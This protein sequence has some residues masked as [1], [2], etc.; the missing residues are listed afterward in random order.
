LIVDVWAEL[1]AL[2]SPM[3]ENLYPGIQ[4]QGV[5]RD[6]QQ[7]ILQFV[8]SELR[9]A[10]P[11]LDDMET[12]EPLYPQTVPDM[13]DSLLSDKVDGMVWVETRME[14]FP[15]P[16]IGFFAPSGKSLSVHYISGMW[17]PVALIGFMELLRWINDLG[18]HIQIEMEQ[19]TAPESWCK[20]FNRTWQAYLSDKG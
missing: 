20:Q 6:T 16:Q 1:Q 19:G 5:D 12:G 3:I 11:V 7:Y 17:D 4:I 13:I 8:C 15:L 10:G 18:D 14:R 9:D 2:F